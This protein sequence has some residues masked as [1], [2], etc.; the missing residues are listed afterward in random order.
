[1]GYITDLRRTL[2]HRPLLM[3]C[4]CL[5]I[6]D[7][8]GNVLLQKRADD[9]LWSNHGGAVELYEPVE[10]ALYRE[11]REELGVV[12]VDPVLLG[13]YS[14]PECRHV[15]PN[16]DE[17]SIVDIVYWCEAFTGDPDYPDGEV[18]AT[19]W[20]PGGGLP[21]D[22]LRH[23]RKPILDYLKLRGFDRG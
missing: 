10:D 18:T 15:Y 16:G 8:R 6:G 5:I 7:G 13:V 1:M 4:A 14:G 3:P 17:V 22:L 21:D 2:G 11:V 9:G 19:R 23:N 12:P 20:F